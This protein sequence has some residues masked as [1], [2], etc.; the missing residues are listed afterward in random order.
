MSRTVKR[1]HLRVTFTSLCLA[2][3]RI[4]S[5]RALDAAPI[6]RPWSPLGLG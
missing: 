1:L 3:K 6:G 2:S 5:T 4:K